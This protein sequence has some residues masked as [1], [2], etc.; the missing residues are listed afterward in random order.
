MNLNLEIPAFLNCKIS[1]KCHE[2]SEAQKLRWKIKYFCCVYSPVS[3]WFV[4]GLEDLTTLNWNFKSSNSNMEL[5]ICYGGDL[6]IWN[7]EKSCKNVKFDSKLEISKYVEEF[8][9]HMPFVFLA[10]PFSTYQIESG[11]PSPFQLNSGRLQKY[12]FW[13]THN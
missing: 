2:Q 10:Y 1:P 9:V 5:S 6:S 3:T 11:Y 12:I 8:I 13:R 4:K 7:L